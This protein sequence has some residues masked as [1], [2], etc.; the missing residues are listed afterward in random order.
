MSRIKAQRLGISLIG[1]MILSGCTAMPDHSNTLVFGT[2]TKFAIDV[3]VSST[4][5]VPEVT[6]GYKRTEAVW[7]PLLANMKDA[8]GNWIPATCVKTDPVVDCKFQS[9][10]KTDAYSVLAS[11]G[12]EFGGGATS[13]VSTPGEGAE[14]AQ[15]LANASAQASGGIAQYFATGL[16]AQNLAKEGGA[17]IVSVQSGNATKERTAEEIM[18]E[19][20]NLTEKEAKEILANAQ[21][22]HNRRMVL[23]GEVMEK[24]APSHTVD[25]A[26]VTL[27]SSTMKTEYPK[28]GLIDD[29]NKAGSDLPKLKAAV[30]RIAETDPRDGERAPLDALVEA[31]FK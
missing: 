27:V 21:Q 23:V 19:S 7:L 24:L 9:T 15:A 30:T 1:L 25:T 12:A 3:G 31:S 28:L 13:E 22:K 16:A 2:E 20:F 18:A 8:N 4:T 5:Q 10:D 11:F 14:E 29:L 26:K 6:V 17:S